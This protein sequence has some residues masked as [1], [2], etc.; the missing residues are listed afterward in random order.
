MT[1]RR[2]ACLWEELDLKVEKKS[3]LRD[4]KVGD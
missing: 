2:Y 4:L 1:S 3:M